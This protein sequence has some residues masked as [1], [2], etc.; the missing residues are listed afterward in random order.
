MS[1]NDFTLY[2]TKALESRL[3]G[4]AIDIERFQRR[5]AT[6]RAEMAEIQAELDR[7]ALDKFWEA[8]P[9]L[10]LAKWDILAVTQE[11]NGSDPEFDWL[12]SEFSDAPELMV[13]QVY[14]IDPKTLQVKL[15]HSVG[16]APRYVTLELARAMREAYLQQNPA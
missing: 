5:I 14:D 13:M 7:R 9:G 11:L 3:A 16:G 1:E 6:T 10:R 8:H 4:L 15:L 12:F 2:E